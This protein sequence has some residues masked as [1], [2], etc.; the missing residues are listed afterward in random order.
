MTFIPKLIL[1]EETQSTRHVI[2]SDYWNEMF[3]LLITQG[4]HNSNTLN[5]IINGND[6]NLGA[7][8]KDGGGVAFN[9][10]KY[11]QFLGTDVT[12]DGDTLQ[13]E[14][15]Q[16]PVGPEGPRGLPTAGIKI[17]GLF[18]TIEALELAH[19]VGEEGDAYAVGTSDNNVLYIWDYL[20]EAWVNIGTVQGVEG[21]QGIQG[22]GVPVGGTTGQVLSK[23]SGADYDTGWTSLPTEL[24]ELSG[25]TSPIQTQLDGKEPLV[26]LTASRALVSTALGALG[27]S[28][29]T[30]AELAHLSGVSSNVQT[31]L[32][33]KLGT[34]ATATNSTR[35]GGRQCFV[36]STTPV[37]GATGDIWFQT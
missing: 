18:A 4:D 1:K 30:A 2:S 8:V 35:W 32:N 16:G 5:R 21:P 19:P 27:V 22:V 26:N 13:V 37:G 12:L 6:W 36:S 10:V 14:T 33:G 17:L 24:A 31:Q 25:V 7:I 34:T 3:N 20:T 15:L 29:V 28:V 23:T 9:R 11:L